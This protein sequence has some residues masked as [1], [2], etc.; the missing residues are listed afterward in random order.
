MGMNEVIEEVRK[1]R[2]RQVSDCGFTEEHDDRH[3]KGELSTAAAVYASPVFLY[4]RSDIGRSLHFND[5]YP[6]PTGFDRAMLSFGGTPAV[7]AGKSR[8]QQLIIAASLIV[9]EI[10]RLDRASKK[11]EE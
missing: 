6:W 8:R 5:P 1:E 3:V 9:A 7:K 4:E 10:E 2:E 11:D